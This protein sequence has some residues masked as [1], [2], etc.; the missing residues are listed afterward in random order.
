MDLSST[1][2]VGSGMSLTPLIIL[3]RVVWSVSPEVVNEAAVVAAA[4]RS[5]VERLASDI[6]L[7]SEVKAS[8][9]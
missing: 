7:D 1:G 4:I 6:L 3:L 2:S 5:V 8:S 9:I